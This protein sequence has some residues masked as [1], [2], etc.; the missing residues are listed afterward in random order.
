VAHPVWLKAMASAEWQ[1]RYQRNWD[2]Y[3]LPQT[4]AKRLKLGEQVGH[5]G[6]WLLQQIYAADAPGWLREIPTIQTLRQVWLRNFY[7]DQGTLHWRHAGNIPPAAAMICS[8]FDPEARYN[9][10]RQTTWTGYKVHLTESCGP[11]EPHL[12]THVITTEATEQDT[13]VVNELHQA[14]AQKNVCPGVHFLDQGYSDSHSMIKA[15]QEY[16]IDMVML[17]RTDH[18]WQ[19]R[20]GQGYALS[21][22]YIDWEAELVTCPQGKQSASW[23]QGHDKKG[24]L[25]F[26]VMFNTTDCDPCPA[27]SLCTNSKRR[28]RKITIRSQNEAQLIREAVRLPKPKNSRHAMPPGLVSRGLFLR[29]WSP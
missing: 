10:N 29:Q 25:R 24:Q 5:D 12:I 11:V 15:V 4:K 16:G 14:L 17:M 27:R 23:V 2:E 22:F 18:S 6:R 20:A 28:R 21:D 9:I 7:E 8:P 3:R 13:E 19:A 1:E 26:E